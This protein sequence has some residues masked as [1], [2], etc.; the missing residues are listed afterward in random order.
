MEVT[1]N[2]NIFIAFTDTDFQNLSVI[3]FDGSSWSYVAQNIADEDAREL[4]LDKDSNDNIYIA[5]KDS[6]N[7]DKATVK[8]Y[9]FLNSTI[10]DVGI[11]GFTATDISH[12][13]LKLDINPLTEEPYIIYV[14]NQKA[15]V[16]KFDG[17]IWSQVGNEIFYDSYGL[18]PII[19]L[20][21]KPDITFSSNGELIATTTEYLNSLGISESFAYVFDNGNWNPTNIGTSDA[22]LKSSESDNNG[23]VY[24]AISNRQSFSFDTI[25]INFKKYS[26]GNFETL[27]MIDTGGYYPTYL[28]LNF[29]NNNVPYVIYNSSP[30]STNSHINKFTTQLSLNEFNKSSSI[31]VFPNPNSGFITVTNINQHS[32]FK[33]YDILGQMILTGIASENEKIDLNVL[34]KGTYFLKIEELSPIKII[35]I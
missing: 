15:Y 1:S 19:G 14:N 13:G 31:E 20:V 23:N 24:F 7:G 35:K 27:E 11:E 16:N 17:V 9:D 4:Q 3:K 26:N 8:K 10:I 5:Y 32:E 12:L 25:G 21:N 18:Y 2:D 6:F 30:N 29:D 28:E 34:N 33:L 22:P